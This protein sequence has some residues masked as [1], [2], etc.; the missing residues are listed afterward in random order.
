MNGQ[1]HDEEPLVPRR[2]PWVLLAG[3]ILFCLVSTLWMLVFVQRVKRIREA[4]YPQTNTLA[5]PTNAPAPARA[6]TKNH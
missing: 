1:S 4:T 6:N 5:A 2:W 3:V